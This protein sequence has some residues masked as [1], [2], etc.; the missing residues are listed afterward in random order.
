MKA[1]HQPNIRDTNQNRHPEICS[2]LLKKGI[3]KD[4]GANQHRQQI[5]DLLFWQTHHVN[6][7]CLLEDKIQDWGMYLFTISYALDQ[8]SGDGWFSGWFDVF[9]NKR[10]SILKYSI[11][12]LLQRWT[13]SSIIL[14]SKEESVWR[15]RRPRSRTVSFVANRLL[16]WSV[17]TS[18]SLE[19]MILSK[20]MPTFTV[21]LRNDDIQEFDSKWDGISLS[22]TKIPPDDILEGLYKLRI[23][24]LEKLKTVLDLYDLE[25]HQKKIGLNFQR[26]KTMVKKEV[27]SKKFEIRILGTEMEISR[28]TPWSRIREQNSVYKE[29][30]EI[31]ENGKPT[32]SVWKETIAV[33]ATIWI[34]VEKL[35][36]QI[37]LR[38]LSCSRMSEKH[39]EPEIPEA[40][41]PAVE[42]LDGLTKKDHLNLLQFIQWKMAPSRM[43]VLQDEERLQIWWKVLI[44]TSSSWSTTKKKSKKNDDKSA[45]AVLNSTQEWLQIWWKMLVNASSRWWTT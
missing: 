45:V 22:M 30:L 28:R 1:K 43:L 29:F 44:C 3:I 37:R 42:C 8:R 6:N 5:S 18:G 15:N 16:T 26:L 31:V 32:G 41:V 39:R 11:R 34:S 35:H 10:N 38:I 17:I 7:V 27:S 19:S 13:E 36:H 33:S 21:G 12:R 24:E 20:T 2:S 9:V 25:I 40:E 14:T 4:Y 23:R